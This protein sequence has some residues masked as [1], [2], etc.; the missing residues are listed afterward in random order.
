[1]FSVYKLAAAL[2]L[3]SA[4]LKAATIP[5]LRVC[6]D[7]NNMPYSNRRGRGFE[8][9]I[10]E[11]I[12]KDLS[13]SVSYFWLPQRGKFFQ[14][15]LTAG[16]CDVVMGVPADFDEVDVTR[17]YYRSSYAF[18]SRHEDYLRIASFDDPRLRTL[19]IGVH[20]L[21]DGDD[22]LPPVHALTMRGI[23]RNLVG[24]SIF[25]N[26]AEANPSAD[27]IAAVI[28]KD[29]DVAVVWGPLAGHF[30]QH[31]KIPLDLTP[32]EKD[33]A[34]PD[35]PLTFDI[36]LGVRKGDVALRD[37]L[38]T[39][40]TRRHAEIERILVSYGLPRPGAIAAARAIDGR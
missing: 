30:A 5:S 40:L 25:G 9:K 18:V 22:S 16:T 38:N 23:V 8:N 17:A 12:A 6:S 21:G 29:V 3:F 39:E 35:L 34:H 4:A 7:P 32:I 33:P 13:S 10:A 1:M 15:T 20:I 19:R 36:C 37:R 27:L 28:K 26:L 11:L 24:Y 31:A 2:F 14:Q